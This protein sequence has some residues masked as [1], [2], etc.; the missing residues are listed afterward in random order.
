MTMRHEWSCSGQGCDAGA[1]DPA[2]PEKFVAPAGY[3]PQDP[4]NF[5]GAAYGEKMWLTGAASDA[6]SALLGPDGDCCG[7]DATG[8]GGCGKCLLVQNPSSLNPDWTAVVMKKGRCLPSSTGCGTGELHFDIAAPGFASF[9]NATTNVCGVRAGTGFASQQQSAILGKWF[10]QCQNTAE[11]AHLCD[12]LPAD[13]QAGCRL[14]A[15][16]GWSKGQPD[17]VNFTVVECPTAFARHIGALSS[18]SGPVAF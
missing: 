13:Y 10:D 14:F 18:A 7:A 4:A 12:E 2:S 3:G 15:S 1:G 11:C 16:W 17:R 9:E 8:V 6:L 5:S